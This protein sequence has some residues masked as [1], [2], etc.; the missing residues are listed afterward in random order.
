MVKEMISSGDGDINYW[1]GV[2]DLLPYYL[3]RAVCDSIH[4][5]ALNITKKMKKKLAT[6][7]SIRQTHVAKE[8]Q[9]Q[10]EAS[11]KEI[12]KKSLIDSDLGLID[13]ELPS[14]PFS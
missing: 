10:K 7:Q 13:M 9:K 1:E 12:Y 8:V 5:E 4:N 3:A 6:E 2:Y 14:V 11:V